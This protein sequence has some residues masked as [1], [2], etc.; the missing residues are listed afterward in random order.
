MK[1]IHQLDCL[2]MFYTDQDPFV[3]LNEPS[4]L[5]SILEQSL[6]LQA[7]AAAATVVPALSCER[8]AASGHDAPGCHCG[9]V[10]LPLPP[11]P[12]CGYSTM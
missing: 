6:L 4:C 2:A 5:V 8:Q 12:S 11:P 7:L 10:P 1:G 3:L 9:A